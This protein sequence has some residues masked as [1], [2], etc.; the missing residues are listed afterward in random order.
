MK[1]KSPKLCKKCGGVLKKGECTN[2]HC[3]EPRNK[4]PDV[5]EPKQYLSGG[6]MWKQ[7]TRDDE[8]LDDG[9]D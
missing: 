2:S 1:R 8:F 9:W 7:P 5:D 4:Y 3:G 6:G